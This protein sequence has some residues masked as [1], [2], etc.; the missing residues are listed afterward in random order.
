MRLLEFAW[1]NMGERLFHA[2]LVSHLTFEVL[3]VE[4]F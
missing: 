4:I 1:R 2:A 3:I